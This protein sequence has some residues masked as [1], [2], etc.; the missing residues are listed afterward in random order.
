MLE[1]LLIEDQIS[2]AASEQGSIGEIPEE[3]DLIWQA[4][5]I[6]LKD[7]VDAYGHLFSELDAEETKLKQIKSDYSER[8]SKALNRVNSLRLRLK[9]RLNGL[10]GSDPLRG[11]L[12]SFHPYVSTHREISDINALS[13]SESYLTVEIRKDYWNML[14]QLFE[15]YQAEFSNRSLATPKIDYS[16]KSVKGK[17]SE[18][19]PDH[20]AVVTKLEPSVR[21]T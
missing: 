18:L 21:I 19:P 13:D 8:I 16:I 10:A 7:K 5:N 12:Y 14:N 20:P 1:K 15:V 2:S 9:S 4:N 11:N 3:L 6:E 17:V